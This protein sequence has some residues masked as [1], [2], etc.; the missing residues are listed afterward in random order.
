MVRVGGTHPISTPVRVI[1]ATNRDLQEEVTA[2]RFREDLYYRIRVVEVLLPPLHQ[3]REDIPL[4][5]EHLLGRIGLRLKRPVHGVAPE[6]MRALMAAPWPGNV[7]ELENVLE[8]ALLLAEGDSLQIGD[9]PDD[10]HG[11]RVPEVGDDLRAA[12]R[13][14]ESHHIRQVLAATDGNRE[15][16]ARRLGI[17]PSTL[18]RR[19]KEL[20][21]EPGGRG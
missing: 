1:T 8:R 11:S 5:I 21:L 16:A 9:L 14:Y 7:R 20:A 2:G 12:V 17:D 4:L 13:A 18:Y 15:E 6:A 3:R 10:L 19:L